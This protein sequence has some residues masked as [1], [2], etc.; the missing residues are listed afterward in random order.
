[1]N[2]RLK[3]LVRLLL[4]ALSWEFSAQGATER[5]IN[6][7]SWLQQYGYLPPGDLRTHSLRS[8]NSVTSAIASMQRFY[9]LTITGTFDTNTIEAMK[10]P[11]CG[12]PDKFGAELKSNLRRKRYAVQGLKWN[13]NDITF[14]IQNYTPKVGEHDTHEAI[15]KAFKVWESVTP[16]RFREIP[17]SYIRDKVEDFADIMIFFAEGFHGDSSPFD[18][19]GGFL[20]HAYFPGNGI[21]GD[22]HFD[23]AEPWT[24]GNRDLLGNDIFLVAVHELGHAL[25]LEHSNDPSAIMAPFYQWMDTEN[26][27][28]P[29]DDRRGIQQL[30][31][32]GSG[33]PH[34]TPHTPY[35]P[36]QPPYSPGKPR[37]GPNICE[38][39]FDSIAILRG[40][41]FVFKDKWFWRVRNNHVMDGYPMPIGHF[42]R[43]LPTHINAAF[44]REDGKFAFFKGDRYWVFSESI[45]DSGFPKT[46]TEMGSGLP[47]DRIDAALFYTPTGQTFYFRGN[48]YYRFNEQSQSVDDGY[49]KAV[50]VWQGVPDN[51]KAAF[52]S[53]DQAYTYFYKSNKYWKFNNQMMRVEPGYPKSA[54]RDW[55]GCPNED[56]K[57]DGGRGGDGHDKDKDKERE[58]EKEREDKD[59]NRDKERERDRETEDETEVIIIEVDEDGGAGSGGGAAAVVVPLFLLVCV[60]ATLAAL[61][62]FRR[63]GT[64]R[65]LLYCQRSLLDKV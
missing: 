47:R 43:G 41:M 53:K 39:H 48:K 4:L 8:P 30:Y 15:R 61:V 27:Q 6:P 14:S 38:G 32:A 52:M 26:F 36:T 59:R 12:V 34:V 56:P 3:C 2:P 29:D 17:Y 58:K 60:I 25:G 22:T 54:L 10:R 21:G 1:M 64:P 20:A 13:K 57:T 44:E 51:I 16:L 5:Q 37:F 33:A 42:W 19:E 31:G 23:A 40:E 7:E 55:M 18:G 35:H 65:R 45:L 9:G 49:P 28:L 62:F 11:R 50:S 24:I 63:Y 46:L